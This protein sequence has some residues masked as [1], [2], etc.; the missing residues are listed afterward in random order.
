M[1]QVDNEN[2]AMSNGPVAMWVRVG[3]WSFPSFVLVLM[4]FVM[5]V[6]VSVVEALV[7]MVDRNALI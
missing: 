4:A 1:A 7:R 6:K 2:V 5:I 3:L